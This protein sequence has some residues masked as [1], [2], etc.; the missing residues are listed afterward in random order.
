MAWIKERPNAYPENFLPP[1]TDQF[2]ATDIPMYYDDQHRFNIDRA[3][4]KEDILKQ[5]SSYPF[6]DTSDVIFADLPPDRGAHYS[7][8]DDKSVLNLKSTNPQDINEWDLGAIGHETMHQTFGP[9]GITAASNILKGSIEPYDQMFNYYDGPKRATD[10]KPLRSSA[11]KDDIWRNEH[12]LID[13]IQNMDNPET[14]K[15]SPEDSLYQGFFNKYHN[16]LLDEVSNTDESKWYSNDGRNYLYYP[17]KWAE[18]FNAP[19]EV[20]RGYFGLRDLFDRS[21]LKYKNIMENYG[22]SAQ[23][24]PGPLGRAARPTLLG[25]ASIAERIAAQDRARKNAAIQEAVSKKIGTSRGG[26]E[27]S[28]GNAGGAQLSSGMTRGQ[29]AAFRMARGGLMDIPLPGRNRDI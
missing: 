18:G 21:A 3:L 13:A 20:R 22:R 26:N 23:Y 16:A 27:Q 4:S 19:G 10:Y 15:H 24:S 17:P 25:D 28:G 2:Y 11:V 14:F 29:H 8:D 1:H 5:S 12:L 9:S 7:Y 6:L